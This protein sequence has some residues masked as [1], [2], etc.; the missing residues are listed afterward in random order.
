MKSSQLIWNA[1]AVLRDYLGKLVFSVASCDSSAGY[2][3][4][5]LVGMESVV[6]GITW[7]ASVVVSL[8]LGSFLPSYFKKKGENLAT[9]EDIAELTK[10]AKEIE[11]KIDEGVW[12]RQRHWELKRE[13]LLEVTRSIGEMD[14]EYFNLIAAFSAA[15]NG[16]L[17]GENWE[18]SKSEAAQEWTRMVR[19]FEGARLL[20][21]LVAGKD[22]RE[23]TSSLSKA[24]TA[25]YPVIKRGDMSEIERTV[26]K[27]VETALQLTM[28]MLRN[29][30]GITQLP[31]MLATS[32][33]TQSSTTQGAAQ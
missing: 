28:M 7:F 5:R 20:A 6:I 33:S 17:R 1:A 11:A 12:G 18:Q 9:K 19:R 13:V 8:V 3:C 16:E 24:F 26:M 21:V 2:N 15:K 30:L 27:P 22:L 23:A 32:Q 10:A 14:G 4:E 31:S 29:E 25:A